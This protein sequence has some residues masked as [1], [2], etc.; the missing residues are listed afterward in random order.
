MK[1]T[2]QIIFIFCL[3]A[4]CDE[5][6]KSDSEKSLD[7]IRTEVVDIDTSSSEKTLSRKSLFGASDTLLFNLKMDS[8]TQVITV[9]VKISSG[10]KI[11]ASVSAADSTANLRINQV[12]FPDNHF[13][14]PFGKDIV[15]KIKDTGTYKIIVAENMMAEGKWLGNFNLKVWV[16]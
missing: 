6:N 16:E 2:L 7:S 11:F 15:F 14:G 4:G 12:G 13:D 10:D 9:P 1:K 3:L 5:G 8:A